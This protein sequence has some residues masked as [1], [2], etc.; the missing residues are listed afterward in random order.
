MKCKNA[1]TSPR[2]DPTFYLCC[3]W[4][5][6]P[7]ISTA[8]A[9][10]SPTRKAVSTRLHSVLFIKSF[11]TG[12]G[13]QQVKRAGSGRQGMKLWHGVLVGT[14][15][16]A[17]SFRFSVRQKRCVWAWV[18]NIED[19]PVRA[20]TVYDKKLPNHGKS[21]LQRQKLRTFCWVK[22]YQNLLVP[23]NWRYVVNLITSGWLRGH[24]R[25]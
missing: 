5:V 7:T 14:P 9:F 20:S 3:F 17:S 12:W 21:E 22:C 10:S 25:F 11:T 23:I 1:T 15:Y 24:L 6:Y 16:F 19:K 2:T 8:A 13:I 18:E 4:K